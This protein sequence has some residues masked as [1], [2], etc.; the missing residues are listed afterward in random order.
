MTSGPPGSVNVAT[1]EEKVFPSTGEI[2]ADLATTAG[3]EIVAVSV[4]VLDTGACSWL[5]TTLI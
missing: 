3:S 4:T 5:T 2:V 1:T